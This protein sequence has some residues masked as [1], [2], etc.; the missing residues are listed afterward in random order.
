MAQLFLDWRA[1]ELDEQERAM[2]EYAD[3]L[4]RVPALM[5]E[6][7][8]Q[9]LRDV[10]FSDVEILDIAL[11]TA[12]RNFIN[13]IAEGLGIEPTKEQLADADPRFVEALY[14]NMGRGRPR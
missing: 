5:E 6:S 9:G 12:Y 11:A 8:V 2:L 14:P 7:D 3:K 10:G 13:R 1:L 4:T